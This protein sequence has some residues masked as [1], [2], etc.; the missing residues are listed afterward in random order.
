MDHGEVF[1]TKRKKFWKKMSD[2]E[3]A[4]EPKMTDLKVQ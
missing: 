4:L 2:G 3:P 1:K